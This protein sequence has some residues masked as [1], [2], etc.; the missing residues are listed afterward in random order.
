MAY[1]RRHHEHRGVQFRLAHLF[2]LGFLALG[3][4]AAC[5][6]ECD[7]DGQG[8]AVCTD[9][10]VTSVLLTLE[11]DGGGA[12]SDATVS[13]SVDGSATAPCDEGSQGTYFCGAEQLG[14]FRITVAAD[15][16]D[17]VDAEIVVDDSD[18]C[19]VLTEE[20]TL[21]LVPSTT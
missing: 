16:F 8:P 19:H 4:I 18:E 7:Q 6:T 21:F 2:A 13:Y 12:V 3:A 1:L 10:A 20:L 14:C 11:D 17:P 9:E 15:G 5:D